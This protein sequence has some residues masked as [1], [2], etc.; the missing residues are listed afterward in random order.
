M[1]SGR[2]TMCR[3]RSARLLPAVLVLVLFG[4]IGCGPGSGRGVFR[5]YEYEEEIY[6]D[7]DGSATVVVNASIP[8][9][10]A[11][12]GF[13]LDPGPR[14]RFDRRRL[15]ALY[16]SDAAEVTRVSS[17]WRRHGRRFVQVR[18]EVA[19]VRRLGATAPFGWSEYRLER[20]QDAVLYRQAVTR[21]A[22]RDV[23][24]VGWSGD[25]LV[26]FRLHLPSRIQFHNAR[27]IFRPGPDNTREV[28]RGNIVSWEQRLTDRLKGEPLVIEARMDTES[29]LYS[30]LWLFGLT[31]A[32]ALVALGG[33]V[34][35][36][37]RG[38]KGTG[39]AEGPGGV[40]AA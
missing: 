37:A 40:K 36:V 28:E 19:D 33:V 16:E 4:T 30:T 31:F 17:P 18:L 14:A 20:L 7:L 10:A 15:R 2:P 6:L 35:W 13:D 5:E 38:P 23:G 34:W 21:T 11:L 27:D 8:A 29:I 25:E 9:L 39:G 26:A 3:G 22:G 12:H 32:A 1:R 24:D